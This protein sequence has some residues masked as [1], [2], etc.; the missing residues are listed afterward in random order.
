MVDILL[1]LVLVVLLYVG[2]SLGILKML[3]A[4]LGMYIGL[5]F[6]A[7]LFPIFAS[8]TTKAGSENSAMTNQIVWFFILWVVWSIIGTLIVWSFLGQVRLPKWLSNLELLGGLILGLLAAVFALSIIGIVAKNVVTLFWIAQGRQG[9]NFLGF[10]K[11]SFDSSILIGI[12][13]TIRFI[14]LS[15]LSPWL[16]SNIQNVFQLASK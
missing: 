7:F 6:A 8:L 15:F 16:P 12:F 3:T 9:D 11:D 5:Q 4:I 10:M 1:V 14:Y 2:F 13:D